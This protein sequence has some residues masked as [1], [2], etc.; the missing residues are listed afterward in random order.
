MPEGMIIKALSGFYYVTDGNRQVRCRARGVFRKRHVVPLVGDHVTYEAK[1]ATEGYILSVGQRSTMLNRPPI[2]NVDQAVLVF[3]VA[4]PAFDD[5]LLDRFLVHMEAHRIPSLICLTKWDLLD[6]GGDEAMRKLM[7]RYTKIGYPVIRTSSVKNLG[8]ADLRKHLEGM[9]NVITGQSGVGKSSLLNGLDHSLSIDTQEISQSLGRGKHTT[10][11]VELL[12]IAA[13]G[14]VADTPGFSSL[15]IPPLSPGE[16]E[17]CFPE[18]SEFRTLCRFRGC[19]HFA[20]PGCAVKKAVKEHLIDVNRYAHY[21]AFSQEI[22][23]R[24]R[25]Y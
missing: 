11:H 20:E 7:A 25:R 9:I 6:A 19:T 17:Q 8:L 22:G 14:F 24:K 3:S 18:F 1:K 2:A 21:Q 13:G 12:P 15:E 4:E 23:K 5:Q 16:L 10:R